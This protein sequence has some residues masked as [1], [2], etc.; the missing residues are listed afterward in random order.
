MGGMFVNGKRTST[1]AEVEDMIVMPPSRRN[2]RSNSNN[3]S[4]GNPSVGA[5]GTGENISNIE[6][7]DEGDHQRMDHIC[8]SVCQ[9]LEIQMTKQHHIPV[10]L[11]TPGLLT[12]GNE[13]IMESRRKRGYQQS[14]GLVRGQKLGSN[15]DGGG[16]GG[17]EIRNDGN[18]LA[19]GVVTAKE[20]ALAAAEK[21]RQGN[22]T[23]FVRPGKNEDV[24]SHGA[25]SI[26]EEEVED[27]K[28]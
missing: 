9:E 26:D 1:L 17:S 14:G 4:N 24:S 10:A 27:N 7:E 21:R 16:D 2:N 3:I 19:A 12:F 28:Q 13:L 6:I 22:A 20:L 11:I 25:K 23:I 15:D 5:R 18:G 8:R